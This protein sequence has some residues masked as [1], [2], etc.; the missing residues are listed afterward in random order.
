VS[1]G[2]LFR[3]NQAPLNSF[4]GEIG[5]QGT[6]VFQKMYCSKSTKNSNFLGPT[7]WCTALISATREAEIEG[8][9]SMIG[10]GTIEK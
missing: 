7:W 9:W 6:L 8:S 3:R 4:A 10:L 1:G 5:K 2:A